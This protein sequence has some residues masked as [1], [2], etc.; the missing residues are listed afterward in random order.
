[1]KD[2]KTTVLIPN[3]K[4]VSEKIH[5][6]MK[7]EIREEEVRGMY[8][9]IITGG[10]HGLDC[11]LARVEVD[12]SRGLPGFEMVGLLGSEVKEARE[13]IRVA[14]R[15]A[16]IELP[17]MRITVNISPASLH[18]AGTFYDL[19]VAAGILAAQGLILSEDVER[20][21]IAGELGLNGEVRPVRGILPMVLEAR[22]QGLERCIIPEE[23]VEEACL[24]EGIHLRGIRG[25]REL[26]DA[27]REKGGR[28]PYGKKELLD[29]AVQGPDF[30]EIRGQE[31][32]KRAAA[33]AAAGFHHMLMI[34][35]PGA[36]KTMIARCLPSILPPMSEEERLEAAS[37]YSVAGL[38]AV[39]FLRGGGR[40]F[41]APH[42]TVTGHALTGGGQVPKPGAVSLA[43][44]GVLFL[45]ELAEFKRATLDLLRQPLEEKL[46]RIIRSSGTYCYPADFMLVAAMN[47]CPCGYYP[48]R[49]RCRCSSGQ[50]ARYLS[51]IS[52]PILDRMDLCAEVER[53]EFAALMK[54]EGETEMDSAGLRIA[55]MEARERQERRFRQDPLLQGSIRYNSQM[56]QRELSRFCALGMPEQQFLELMFDR[57][58]LTARSCHRLLRVARTLADLDGEERIGKVHLSEAACLR[59]TAGKYTGALQA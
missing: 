47:P 26:A 30:G 1:M 16:E 36:G 22:R 38:P 28:T 5:V 34:G 23:N 18:K 25:L 11:Y 39:S 53:V 54:Q 3:L 15:N 46:V 37:I 49:N 8:S 21:M 17:P 2:R 29:Q 55:V 52:G 35:P 58:G 7:K 56:G 20:V 33:A 32:A 13:R 41:V 31:G 48:D 42:H 19:P 10:L 9:T 40:P 12:C 14:L 6:K 57:L 45:D 4:K 50:V 51:G 44:R 24:V 43:H 59:L 27:V